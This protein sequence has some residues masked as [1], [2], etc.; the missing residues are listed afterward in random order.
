MKGNTFYS[1][2]A[3]KKGNISN[4]FDSD[5]VEL[6]AESLKALMNKIKTFNNVCCFD[7][8]TSLQFYKWGIT[9]LENSID[10]N[11][12][13]SCLFPEIIDAHKIKVWGKT[14]EI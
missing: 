2:K 8:W 4:F 6:Y 3:W 5:S 1:F 11:I 10:I 13:S 9:H 12:I 7:R 14:Y